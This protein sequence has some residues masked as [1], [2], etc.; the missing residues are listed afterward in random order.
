[1]VQI[2]ESNGSIFSRDVTIRPHYEILWQ[3]LRLL[4]RCHRRVG[5]CKPMEGDRLRDIPLL[6]KAAD[7]SRGGFMLQDEQDHF[8]FAPHP[9]EQPMLSQV[10]SDRNAIKNYGNE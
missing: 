3:E 1:M 2:P 10:A 6:N 8:R 7:G 9:S 4:Q 5:G